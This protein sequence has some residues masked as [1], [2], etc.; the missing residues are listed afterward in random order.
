PF[1]SNLNPIGIMSSDR[2]ARSIVT[3]AKRDTRNIIVTVNPLT[4]ILF[5][6]REL[7]VSLYFQAFSRG[8]R[9]TISPSERKTPEAE[10][11]VSH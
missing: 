10:T 11:Q 6:F 1:K 9:A 8:D 3:A 2:V 5:P 7:L 4:H